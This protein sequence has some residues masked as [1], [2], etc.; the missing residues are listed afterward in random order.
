MC[1]SVC[2]WRL[3]FYNLFLNT[4]VSFQHVSAEIMHFLFSNKT[5]KRL[6]G[7]YVLIDCTNHTHKY[8]MLKL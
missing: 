5:T 6:I 8:I 3:V 7:Y 1:V 2:C 4:H